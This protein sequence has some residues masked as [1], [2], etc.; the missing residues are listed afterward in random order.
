MFIV[1]LSQGRLSSREPSWYYDGTAADG[2]G[3]DGP[4]AQHEL[5]TSLER[6]QFQLDALVKL[7]HESL[8]S[9]RLDGLATNFCKSDVA[10]SL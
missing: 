4:W 1:G 9:S 10:K 2:G 7:I 6:K 3:S 8:F 5:D